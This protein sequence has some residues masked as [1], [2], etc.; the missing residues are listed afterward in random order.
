M[1]KHRR[2]SYWSLVA[3]QFRRNR[4]ARPAL[5]VVLLLFAIA[6]AAP[7]LAGETPIYMVMEGRTYVFPNVINYRE[8]VNADFES[9]KPGDGEYALRPLIQ[10]DPDHS[11]LRDRLQGPTAKHWLGTDDRGRDVLARLIWG[12]RISMSVG[13]IAVGIAVFIGIIV[14]A[15]AGFYGGIVDLAAQRIIEIVMCFPT[16]ILILSLIAFL[17]PSIYNIMVVIGITGWTGVARL[18][19]GEFLRLRESDFSIAARATGLTDRRIMFRHLLPNALS[20]VLVSATFGVAGAILTESALSFLGFGV[21][22]PTPS[23]G[24][25]LSQSQRFIDRAWWLVTFPGLAIF[26]TVTAFN[27]VGEGLRDAMDPRLRQ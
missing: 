2:L 24:E 5:A 27:L 8:L 23:W 18:I 21:P 1:K 6:L 22:P 11:N 12:T 15:F 13:F 9:W 26:I 17:P 25:L 14:G 19:R 16:F 7:F 3:R 10:Y 20:P 4:L